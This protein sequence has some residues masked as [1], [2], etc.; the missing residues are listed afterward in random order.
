MHNEGYAD[1]MAVVFIMH[2][3]LKGGSK[4]LIYIF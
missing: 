1:V 2:C 4:I 3:T